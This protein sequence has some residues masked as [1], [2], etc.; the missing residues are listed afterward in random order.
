[1][2]AEELVAQLRQ[3]WRQELQFVISD[4]GAQFIAQAFAQFAQEMGFLHV[5]I[6]PQRPQTNGI[7]ERFVRTLKEWLAWHTWQSP[8]ELTAL[9]AEFIDYDNERPHQG[10]ELAGLSPNE[11]ARRLECSTGEWTLQNALFCSAGV[12]EAKTN[13]KTVHWL[14]YHSGFGMVHE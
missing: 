6:A 11:F 14:I 10:A 3:H 5:R 2:T 13:I 12:V 9:L 4:N 1:V 8:E 7:A